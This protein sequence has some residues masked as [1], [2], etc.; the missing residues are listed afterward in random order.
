MIERAEAIKA[1]P[2]I[3]VAGADVAG[4]S[5]PEWVLVATLIYTLLQIYLLVRRII[6]KGDG[7]TCAHED[8]PGRQKP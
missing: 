2:P 3:A 1:A 6:R 7:M 8:C 5:L 4:L